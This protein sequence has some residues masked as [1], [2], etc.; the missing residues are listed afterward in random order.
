MREHTVCFQRSTGFHQSRHIIVTCVHSTDTHTVLCAH[1]PTL[2]WMSSCLHGDC[3]LAT[4][5]H[6]L[7]HAHTCLIPSLSRLIKSK[8]LSIICPPLQSGLCPWLQKTVI[9]FLPASLLLFG[10]FPLS[11][12][13]LSQPLQQPSFIKASEDSC[14]AV[15]LNSGQPS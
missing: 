13:R 10:S 12:S 15:D 14:R 7:S 5:S 9:L 8:D 6:T 1:F 11:L 4:H 3:L 2:D